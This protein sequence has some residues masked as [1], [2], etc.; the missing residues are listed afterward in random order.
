[1]FFDFSIIK[2]VDEVTKFQDFIKNYSSDVICKNYNKSLS[3]SFNPKLVT[4][5][6]IGAREDLYDEA[7]VVSTDTDLVPAI[8]YIRNRLGK[9]VVVFTSIIDLVIDS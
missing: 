5:M 4:D 3:V 2:N 7:L 9:K 8:N 1:M 6:L